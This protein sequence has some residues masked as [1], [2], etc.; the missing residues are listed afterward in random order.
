MFNL[1]EFDNSRLTDT[2]FQIKDC[3]TSNGPVMA[4][5]GKVKEVYAFAFFLVDFTERRFIELDPV[6]NQWH[7][8]K[9]YYYAGNPNRISVIFDGYELLNNVK[10]KDVLT[11]G[12]PTLRLGIYRSGNTVYTNSHSIVDYKNIEIEKVKDFPNNL[13]VK[14]GLFYKNLHYFCF[15]DNYDDP[16]VY[17]P[18]GFKRRCDQG[19]VPISSREYFKIKKIIEE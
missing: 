5:L 3:P 9:I 10:F 2:F 8:I 14:K 19:H 12:K 17:T 1:L 7:D 4:K 13:K 11:C 18:L 6:N 15:N 16:R